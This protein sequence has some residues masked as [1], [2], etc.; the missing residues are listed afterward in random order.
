VEQDLGHF[1]APTTTF[2]KTD[3]ILS[4]KEIE[5]FINVDIK[6]VN[7]RFDTENIWLKLD[8]YITMTCLRGITWC[9]MAWIEYQDPN[10]LIRNGFTYKKIESYLDVQFLMDI[11]D[12]FFVD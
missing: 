5:E 7:K 6:K 10:K 2:W 8:K 1:L 3:I 11:E 12:E 4:R 9:S